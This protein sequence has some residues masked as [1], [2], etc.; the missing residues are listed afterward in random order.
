MNPQSRE[1]PMKRQGRTIP[2]KDGVGIPLNHL[3]K[4][5]PCAVRP[6]EFHQG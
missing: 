6:T 5:L 2:R 4:F 1:C 3:T